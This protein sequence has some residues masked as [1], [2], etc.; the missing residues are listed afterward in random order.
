MAESKRMR[1][2][3]N[4]FFYKSPNSIHDGGA[5]LGLLKGEPLKGEY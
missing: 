1:G 2:R 4:S 3:L 5:L